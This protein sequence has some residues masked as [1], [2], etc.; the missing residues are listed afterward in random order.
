MSTAINI[1]SLTKENLKHLIHQAEHR[2][3]ALNTP[4]QL[5]ELVEDERIYSIVNDVLLLAYRTGVTKA[6]VF[7]ALAG[8]LRQPLESVAAAMPQ[9]GADHEPDVAGESNASAKAE[10]E[11]WAFTS[12]E[13][14]NLPGSLSLGPHR[15]GKSANTY[16]VDSQA[17]Y[18]DRRRFTA[19]KRSKVIYAHPVDT[20][21]TWDGSGAMPKWL[22]DALAF[23]RKLEE[24]R[25]S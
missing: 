15:S 23:G 8:A 24:F 21:R 25:V 9:S 16:S 20:D 19:A 13:Q 4:P 10:A 2:L 1:E 18:S 6:D 22:R 5:S 3:A 12:D 14:K 7:S 17:R 11:E